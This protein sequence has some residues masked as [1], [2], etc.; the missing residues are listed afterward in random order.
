MAKQKL[1]TPSVM[2]VNMDNLCYMKLHKRMY[3]VYDFDKLPYIHLVHSFDEKVF[4]PISDEA[5][6]SFLNFEMSFD[7]MLLMFS[8]LCVRLGQIKLPF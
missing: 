6:K 4:I 8:S 2:S 7:T 1:S 5:A 3:V